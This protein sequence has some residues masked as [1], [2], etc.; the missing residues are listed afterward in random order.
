MY[1][2]CG[3][4]VKVAPWIVAS[5]TLYDVTVCQEMADMAGKEVIIGEVFAD[6]Y[7]LE[8]QGNYWWTDDLLIPADALTY[9]DGACIITGKRRTLT[10]VVMGDGTIVKMTKIAAATYCHTCDDCGKI[11]LRTNGVGNRHFD[12]CD[13]PTS[14]CAECLDKKDICPLCGDMMVSFV[15][16]DGEK[17]CTSCAQMNSVPCSK[18]GEMHLAK[19]MKTVD[20]H[21][22]CKECASKLVYTECPACGKKMIDTGKERLCGDCEPYYCGINGYHH[23]PSLRFW[24]DENKMFGMELEVDDGD[25]DDNYMNAAEV[26]RIMKYHTYCCHDG[27]LNS[28]FEIITHPHTYKGMMELPWEEMCRYLI[29]NDWRGHD[30][31]TAGMHIHISRKAFKDEDA[32][33]R[34]ILFFENNW[35]FCKIF[36]RRNS[37]KIRTWAAPYLASTENNI[38]PVKYTKDQVDKAKSGRDRRHCVNLTNRNTVEVRLFRSSLNPNTIRATLELVNLVVDQANSITDKDAESFTPSMWLKEASDNLK[39]YCASRRIALDPMTV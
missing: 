15:V 28:G 21:I 24:G 16:I 31:S 23:G 14:L 26:N 12:D 18:C 7:T 22:F 38:I 29:E 6:H 4:K 17:M 2:A 13:T 3:T 34:F 1:F 11:F 20:G 5:A 39:T 8:G 35:E 36:S 10:N 9:P 30:T 25:C 33:S 19:N 37:V 27:S 32:I